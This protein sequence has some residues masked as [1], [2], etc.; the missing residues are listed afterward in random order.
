MEDQ[1]VSF[2][3]MVPWNDGFDSGDRI[4]DYFSL[5]LD[6]PL[7][8]E[9]IALDSI[10]DPPQ[11]TNHS[12]QQTLPAAA[13]IKEPS[14]VFDQPKVF[15]S[16][17][18]TVSIPSPANVQKGNHANMFRDANV[19]SLASIIDESMVSRNEV[20]DTQ[21]CGRLLEALQSRMHHPKLVT[22]ISLMIDSFSADPNKK[23][24][25]MDYALSQ[26]SKLIKKEREKQ[27][28]SEQEKARL[29]HEY[30][31]LHQEY[32]RLQSQYARCAAALTSSKEPHLRDGCHSQNE[33]LR[34]E[35]LVEQ[36]KQHIRAQDGIIKQ[37]QAS[38]TAMASVQR[39]QAPQPL[40]ADQV[41]SR[42]MGHPAQQQAA[43]TL[44]GPPMPTQQDVATILPPFFTPI[45]QP[46][47]FPS[48][49]LPMATQQNVDTTLPGPSTQFQQTDAVSTAVSSSVPQF[50]SNDTIDLTVDEDGTRTHLDKLPSTPTVS[51][52]RKYDWMNASAPTTAPAPPNKKAKK[53]TAK[54]PAAAKVPAKKPAP[55]APKV[56]KE[57]ASRRAS[58]KDRQGLLSHN[59]GDLKEYQNLYA[60]A[61]TEEQNKE[62]EEERLQKVTEHYRP[63]QQAKE[64][65]D[66]GGRYEPSLE[67]QA[68]H[69]Q[70]VNNVY[71]QRGM[72]NVPRREMQHNVRDGTQN[73]FQTYESE[74]DT[75]DAEE[76][77]R[78][79]GVDDAVFAEL[80]HAELSKN[81]EE[82]IA[83]KEVSQPTRRAVDEESE[84]SEEE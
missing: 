53:T 84:E 63:V 62:L 55:K 77:D 22:R 45:P 17:S 27:E 56:L 52:K 50:T 14:S 28:A 66:N 7:E 24:Q 73:K 32:Q 49:A 25:P 76:E 9:A 26:A 16:T 4:S 67:D 48:P 61:M 15:G 18:S 37:T 79:D 69:R 51:N 12:T 47:A 74:S 70:Q 30:Q 6:A 80:L 36:Y 46:L 54:A 21:L 68:K 31:R 39:R 64:A 13:L 29:R 60:H 71:A 44:P 42:Y 35:Q 81:D 38:L 65:A 23:C 43:F 11:I 72:E 57:K 8:D 33:R 20:S 83:Q 3:D 10:S 1:V 41:R 19:A 34:L 82:E 2:S 5:P 59:A 75:D 78:D 40:S 58:K